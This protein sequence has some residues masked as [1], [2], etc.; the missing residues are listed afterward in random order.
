MTI[1]QDSIWKTLYD[2]NSSDNH[3]SKTH[4]I[5]YDLQNYNSGVI[6][7]F[8]KWSCFFH[9]KCDA[10]RLLE[11]PELNYILSKL[12]YIFVP[13]RNMK[14]TLSNLY[15]ILINH[16]VVLYQPI[17]FEP[18]EGYETFFTKISTTTDDDLTFMKHSLD[19][20]DYMNDES[21]LKI[22][23]KCLKHNTPLLLK[24]KP[25]YEEYLGTN[26]PLFFEY[27]YTND[28]YISK[29]PK[30]KHHL[31]TKDKT[32][33][34]LESCSKVFKNRIDRIIDKD[35]DNGSKTVTWIVPCID[36][37][38]VKIREFITNTFMNQK[39]KY[40]R[41]LYHLHI[42]NIPKSHTNPDVIQSILNQ[43]KFI[44][45]QNVDL[46][47]SNIKPT[48]ITFCY[49]KG[50]S[51]TSG[52]YVFCVNM[53]N[54]LP[55]NTI[56]IGLKSLSTNCDAILFNHHGLK[57][58]TYL[59]M[60]DLWNM[61]KEKTC[62]LWRYD[63]LRHIMDNYNSTPMSYIPIY[64]IQLGYNIKSEIYDDDENSQNPPTGSFND[65]FYH[66]SIKKTPEMFY[67]PEK[68]P[69]IIYKT[70]PLE[71]KFL[72]KNI[73]D[74]FQSTLKNNPELSIDYFDNTR[75]IWFLRRYF[76]GS[77]HDTYLK[78]KPGAYKA[79]LFRF[80]VLYINGGIYSD[81]SQRFHIPI[82]DIVDYE[83]DSLVLV[84]DIV[85]PPH[86]LPGIQINFMASRPRNP[87]FLSAIQRIVENVSRNFY[88]STSLDPTGPYMFSKIYHTSNV[89]ARMDLIQIHREKG[90][91]VVFKDNT[92][93]VVY[94]NKSARHDE[95]I[96]K[97]YE[98][99]YDTLW[100]Q[101]RI[102]QSIS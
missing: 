24:R 52:D 14:H 45:H 17:Q 7:R 19:C 8:P 29:I 36:S 31:K 32:P 76:P 5:L 3:P 15:P 41:D 68:I 74:L 95:N 69:R 55:S 102:Y 42:V 23:Y 9:K 21:D 37:D 46:K 51:Y 18:F 1:S 20:I 33:F 39:K 88:G 64:G 87:L 65:H 72:S 60:N 61:R 93:C 50:L 70:G 77:I 56:K 43:Y 66:K 4:Y 6:H 81:F 58:P 80:C 44:T 92:K 48:D 94:D 27:S 11:L 78:I 2:N 25:E 26:Y 47:H 100:R 98:N 96:K 85:L 38:A 71:Y 13:H 84:E 62:A 34:S 12:I 54:K 73:K 59:D 53:T 89:T 30:A 22:I 97:T 40:L 90:S 82:K 83:N 63:T 28:K 75:C 91:Y 49:K 67:N 101:R 86:T 10:K 16:L 57:I 99:S 35:V 79:D